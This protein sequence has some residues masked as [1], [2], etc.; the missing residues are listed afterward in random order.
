MS[1][2]ED[3]LRQILSNHDCS[4]CDEKDCGLKPMVQ[5]L[6][7]HGDLVIRACSIHAKEELEISAEVISK[8]YHLAI[9]CMLD[10]SVVDTI[11]NVSLCNYIL[12]FRDGLEAGK[13][14]SKL[15]QILPD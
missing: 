9:L 3:M 4:K 5:A 13:S 11:A 14:I 7:E 10:S 8:N 6:S 15:E 12:G 2:G 1:Q